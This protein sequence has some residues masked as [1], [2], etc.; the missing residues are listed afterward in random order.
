MNKTIPTI[1]AF[2]LILIAAI[3]VDYAVEADSVKAEAEMVRDTQ[4]DVK[5]PV[6]QAPEWVVNDRGQK[7]I[8]Q[9]TSV[10]C[11]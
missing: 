8:K 4:A 6:Y 3:V 10:T 1:V 11:G 7:C 9:G 5:R 2:A